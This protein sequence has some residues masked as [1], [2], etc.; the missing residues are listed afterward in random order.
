MAFR[1]KQDDVV[2]FAGGAKGDLARW[3]R[4]GF[5]TARATPPTSLSGCANQP[6]GSVD[7]VSPPSDWFQCRG[8]SEPFH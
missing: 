6:P 2:R 4:W 3:P 7:K 8:R 1:S 5:L